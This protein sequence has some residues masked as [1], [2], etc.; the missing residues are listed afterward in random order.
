MKKSKLGIWSLCLL[1]QIAG[2]S[3]AV[4]EEYDYSELREN[5]VYGGKLATANDPFSYSTVKILSFGRFF[6]SGTL[7]APD[8]VISAAHCS[9]GFKA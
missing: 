6:C 8:I 5:I 2:V 7:V 4:A 1:M 9:P 3:K